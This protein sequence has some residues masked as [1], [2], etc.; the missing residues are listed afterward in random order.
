MFTYISPVNDDVTL[1]DKFKEKAELKS[2]MNLQC[3]TITDWE[4]QFIF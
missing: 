3:A 4:I 2:T 1:R